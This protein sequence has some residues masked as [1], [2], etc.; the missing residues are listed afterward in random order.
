MTFK[1]KLAREYPGFVGV[2]YC[3]CCRGCPCD[4]G[5]ETKEQSPC[6]HSRLSCSE[7]W[8]RT[9][10]ETEEKKEMTLSDLK[11]GMIIT[12][13]NGVEYIVFSDTVDT[14]VS[15]DSEMIFT[16]GDVWCSANKYSENMK[17]KY[18]KNLD[19]IKVE[20]PEFT[21]GFI[22]LNHFRE[23]RKTLWERQEIKEMT[24]TD[25]EKLVGCRVKIVGEC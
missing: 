24:V 19:I 8:N 12:L 20:S 18:S 23:T 6:G 16:N 13:R 14:S 25:V 11:T 21:L 22:N 7:C 3:A 17:N 4:Y 1:E 15:C 5:Y 2:N 10:P 9:I